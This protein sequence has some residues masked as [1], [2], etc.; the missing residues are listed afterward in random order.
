MAAAPY[1]H[2]VIGHELAHVLA[3]SFGEGPFR[4]AGAAGGL[5]PNPGLI[6]GVAVAQPR[7]GA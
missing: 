6:E 2:P 7:Q 3:G 1:P 4:V 5:V